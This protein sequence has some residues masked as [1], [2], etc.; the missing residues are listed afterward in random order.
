MKSN[1]FTC[2]QLCYFACPAFCIANFHKLASAPDSKLPCLP[3]TLL[4]PIRWFHLKIK[5]TDNTHKGTMQAH[6]ERNN[7][8]GK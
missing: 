5:R 2:A 7:W 3:S 1:S 4:Q 6:R 8:H